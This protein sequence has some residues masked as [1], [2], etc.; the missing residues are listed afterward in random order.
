MDSSP[1]RTQL[2]FN[3]LDYTLRRNWKGALTGINGGVRVGKLLPDSCEDEVSL[4][5]AIEMGATF[6]QDAPTKRNKR[7]PYIRRTIHRG[8]LRVSHCFLTS[9]APATSQLK[10]RNGD[11]PVLTAI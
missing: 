9:C 8:G 4:N 5:V 6:A 2:S 1:C 3:T 7:S 10:G 11:W